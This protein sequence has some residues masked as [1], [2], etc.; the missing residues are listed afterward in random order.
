[1]LGAALVALAVKAG[2]LPVAFAGS[3]STQSA[4]L[5]TLCMVSGLSERLVPNIVKRIEIVVES[6]RSGTDSVAETAGQSPRSAPEEEKLR[7]RR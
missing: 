1:M 6:T 7:D 5:A 4:F 2:V 3:P